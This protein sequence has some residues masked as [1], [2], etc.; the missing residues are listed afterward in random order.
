MQLIEPTKIKVK[1][2]KFSC[3]EENMRE[4]V[5]RGGCEARGHYGVL[6]SGRIQIGEDLFSHSYGE[7]TLVKVPDITVLLFGEPCDQTW[8]SLDKLIAVLSVTYPTLSDVVADDV[9]KQ[10]VADRYGRDTEAR[11]M[12]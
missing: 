8:E 10:E 12:P 7:K 1:L 6:P 3:M 2:S 11:E 5:G 4:T 9:L